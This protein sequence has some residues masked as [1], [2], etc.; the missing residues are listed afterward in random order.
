MTDLSILKD[1][2]IVEKFSMLP[3]SQQVAYMWRMEWL[4]KAH[5]HQILPPDEWWTIWLLLAG[6]GAG[7]TRTAAE[8]LGWWAWTEP[9]TR[10]LVAAPT[11]SDV[12]SV[13]F[14]GESGLLNV[15][16]YELIKEFKSQKQELYLINGS[17]IKGIPA[18]EP[19]R[20]RGPQFHGGWFDELAAWDYL[21]EAWDMIQFGMRLGTRVRQIASTTPKP[22]ELI[23]QLIKQEGKDVVITRASTYANLDNLAPQFKEQILKYEGTKL[24]RQEIYAEVINPE[25]DG[26]IKR[27]WIKVWKADKPLPEFEYIIMSLDTAFTEKTADTKGDPDPSACSV[28]G[29]FKHDKKPAIILLDCWEEHLGLPDLITRVKQEMNVQYGQ[30]DLKPVIAPL[31]GPKSSYLVGRKPDLVLIEDK[32]SGISLRQMLAREEILAYPYN[33]GRADKLARLHM[34][35]HIFAHG[36]VWVVESEKRPGQIKTWAEPL[37]SQLCSFTGEKSIKHDDLMDSTTQ[38]IRF[39]SD[40]NMLAMTVKQPEPMPKR[41]KQYTNPYAI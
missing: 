18:S 24:G 16:P 21:Q 40:K 34:V 2:A 41:Q 39:L 9:N 11:S 15:I 27:S 37:V 12:S 22:K 35:S 3:R 5:A 32:G 30:G 10:W 33:P 23:K 38:A 25:E 8:Q 17:M 7:K 29:Y 14:E 36:Y 4:S 1:P 26:I 31:V 13:C 20:F 28:W 6:R 19:E